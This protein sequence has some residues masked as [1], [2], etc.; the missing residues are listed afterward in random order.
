[1][2]WFPCTLIVG[3]ERCIS[4]YIGPG[5]SGIEGYL[6]VG[7]NC[8]GI[9][10]ARRAKWGRGFLGRASQSLHTMQLGLGVVGQRCRLPQWG[11]E[12]RPRNSFAVFLVAS[13]ATF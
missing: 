3:Y 2:T 8:K 12:P 5:R 4:R 7:D 11:P 13:P 9:G 6:E 10:K 1:M